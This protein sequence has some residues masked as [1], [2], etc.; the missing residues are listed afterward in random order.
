[1]AGP[2]CF[3][4]WEPEVQR[5]VARHGNKAAMHDF[6]NREF[7]CAKW[8]FQLLKDEIRLVQPREGG[9][10]ASAGELRATDLIIDFLMLGRR[11]S[12]RSPKKL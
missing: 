9:S 10:S 4:V 1:M 8:L 3:A 6:L 12:V 5:F 7:D 2:H 11:L